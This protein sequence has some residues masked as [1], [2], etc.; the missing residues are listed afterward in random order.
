MAYAREGGATLVHRRLFLTEAWA[1]DEAYAARRQRCGVPEAAAIFRTKPQLALAMLTELVVEGTLPA[2]W[3][4]CDEGYGR[5]VDF[6]DGV[7]ALGLGCLAEVPVDT[8]VWPTRPPGRGIGCRGTAA[9]SIRHPAGGGLP[10]PS[11]GSRR[12]ARAAPPV[13]GGYGPGLPLPCSPPHQAGAQKKQPGL[14]RYQ[15][16]EALNAVL[17]LFRNLRWDGHALLAAVL[18]RLQGRAARNAAAARSHARR[19]W[20]A[21]PP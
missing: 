5:S 13:R 12:L 21:Q 7:A 17:A 8:R 6:L 11:A 2:R 10:R 19:R 20:V 18:D 16:A 4:S 9:A 14:T 3:V 15:V 1:G